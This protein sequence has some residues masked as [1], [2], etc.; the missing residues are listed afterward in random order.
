MTSRAVR[1]VG[2]EMEFGLVE[3]GLRYFNADS[4]AAL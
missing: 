3:S 1:D 4:G 2:D